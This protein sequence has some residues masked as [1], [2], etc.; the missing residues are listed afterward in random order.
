MIKYAVS[1]IYEENSLAEKGLRTLIT[2]KN[3]LLINNGLSNNFWAEVIE[4]ANYF[5][6]KLATR[7]KTMMR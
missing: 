2:I 6:N 4:T 1:Y 7:N 3:L 5:C